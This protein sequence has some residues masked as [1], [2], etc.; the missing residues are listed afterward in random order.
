MINIALVKQFEN[1]KRMN[2]A[3]ENILVTSFDMT[4]ICAYI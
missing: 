3:K 4:A 2:D 1:I